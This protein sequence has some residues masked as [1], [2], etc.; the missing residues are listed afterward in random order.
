MLKDQVN[1]TQLHNYNNTAK[2]TAT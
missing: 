2:E 1:N